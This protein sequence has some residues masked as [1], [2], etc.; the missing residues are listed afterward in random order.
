MKKF[1]AFII[2]S[3][4]CTTTF[5]QRIAVI[6]F[7]AGVG[8]SQAD[9]DG[10]SAIFNTYFSP[11]GY[12]LVERSRID[13]VIDEQRFQRGNLTEQQMVRIGRILNI[14]QIVV[15]DVNIVMN[16]YNIDVRVLNVETGTIA[17]KEGATWSQG[18]SY[19]TMMQQLATRLAGKIA[20]SPNASVPPT[21]TVAQKPAGVVV[22]HNYLKVYPEDL[23]RFDSYPQNIVEQINRNA[24]YGYD[25]W[26]LPTND[27]MDLI[28][29]NDEKISGLS[30][31]HYMTSNNKN[32]RG[33][34]RL[35]TDGATKAATQEAYN[36]CSTIDD[37]R[38]FIKKYPSSTY[39]SMAKKKIK[40]LEEQYKINGH[41]YV[42][43]GLPSGLKWATC[44]VGASSPEGYGNYYAWGETATKSTYTESNSTTYRK[45]RSDISGNASYDAARANW[46]ST[47]RMPTSE[48][49][50]E[51]KS[52]CTWKWTSQ[53]GHNGYKI[54]GPN[55]NSIF[56]PAAGY[57]NWSSLDYV[58]QYGYYWSS[59]PSNERAYNLFF[60]SGAYYLE[61]LC[62]SFGQ[63]V[64]P[65]SN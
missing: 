41:E 27:E 61:K 3:L 14:S 43:L 8:I 1:F 59:T 23:G 42:D 9:V 52:K 2:V 17:A 5:A 64:R 53:G 40:T 65:V 15:G 18:S 47:W 28:F 35:V 49:I 25:T 44:N 19:R 31:T 55:G 21:S 10:I 29:A 7:N 4:L 34:V 48:E 56:L 54:T 62:R 57:R 16:Q 11:Q 51:L 46:S 13:R 39:V 37:Y 60:H 58:G 20:I 30:S 32:S 38:N 50:Y 22:L 63:S 12:T 24:E 33:N 26:R 6:D 45:S 36:R